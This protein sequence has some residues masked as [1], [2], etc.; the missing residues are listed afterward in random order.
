MDGTLLSKRLAF[1]LSS[2]RTFMQRKQKITSDD[3]N[4]EKIVY[5]VIVETT[6]EEALRAAN[7]RIWTETHTSIC[8]PTIRSIAEATLGSMDWKSQ[9]EGSRVCF[10][11]R[12]AIHLGHVCRIYLDL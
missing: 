7:D 11:Y 1:H 6:A 9:W 2:W 3:G 8:A 10:G 4:N 5:N 12:W